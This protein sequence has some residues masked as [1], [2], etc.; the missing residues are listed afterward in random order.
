MIKSTIELVYDARNGEKQ[1]IIQIEITSWVTNQIGVTYTV[2]DY[3]VGENEAKQLINTKD[4]FYTNEQLN[5]MDVLISSNTDFTGMSRTEIEWLKVKNAL[6]YVTQQAPVYGSIAS[7]W[8][9]T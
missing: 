7:N 4:V 1:A 8:I 2:N 5:Q 9:L 3:A 6:L